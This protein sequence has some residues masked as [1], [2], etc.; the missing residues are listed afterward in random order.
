M[1]ACFILF[2][3]STK[4]KVLSQPI[5]QQVMR[6]QKNSKSQL[7]SPFRT[8]FCLFTSM[9]QFVEGLLNYIDLIALILPAVANCHQV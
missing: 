4:I 5:T 2:L 8:T 7:T 9:K 3:Q 1:R 6:N